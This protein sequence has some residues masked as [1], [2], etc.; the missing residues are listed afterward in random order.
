MKAV[1]TP[2]RLWGAA[3]AGLTTAPIASFA[4]NKM[5]KGQ[6]AFQKSKKIPGRTL[7]VFPKISIGKKKHFFFRDGGKGRKCSRCDRRGSWGESR[8]HP[9]HAA[10]RVYSRGRRLGPCLARA[11]NRA[12]LDRERAHNARSLHVQLLANFA[13]STGTYREAGSAKLIRHD[14]VSCWFSFF[15]CSRARS[16]GGV[17]TNARNKTH[18][19]SRIPP[20]N[21][22]TNLT[23][24]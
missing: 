24:G 20:I 6:K 1:W 18:F 16:F 7:L 22:A 9:R 5:R 8:V 21:L 11:T 23:Q 15:A 10:I 13:T 14:G 2:A 17:V 12:K 19:R 4:G 3:M